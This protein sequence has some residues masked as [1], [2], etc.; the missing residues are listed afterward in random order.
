MYN[1]D[2]FEQHFDDDA[3]VNDHDDM[4]DVGHDS[5]DLDPAEIHELLED[6][7][8]TDE[9]IHHISDLLNDEDN[10]ENINETP[11]NVPEDD[12]SHEI[13]FKAGSSSCLDSCWN[14][15]SGTCSGSCMVRDY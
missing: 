9:E 10:N 6:L 13:S 7:N 14:T 8:L 2:S 1:E 3:G 12:H 11:G 5:P 4:I 15:C